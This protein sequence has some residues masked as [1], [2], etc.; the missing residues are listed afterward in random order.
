MSIVWLS[1]ILYLIPCLREEIC[2]VLNQRQIQGSLQEVLGNNGSL[3]IAVGYATVITIA[4]ITALGVILTSSFYTTIRSL[5]SFS[6]VQNSLVVLSALPC[7]EVL[8]SYCP[9]FQI[10][11]A[12]GYCYFI[13]YTLFMPAFLIV[14]VTKMWMPV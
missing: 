6:A 4:L 5:A 14:R 1:I 13:Q 12:Y 3:F 10:V 8:T 2:G 9:I 11:L 7:W